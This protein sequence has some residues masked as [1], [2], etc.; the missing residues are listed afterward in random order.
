MCY[1]ANDCLILLQL[2]VDV[3]LDWT[4]D[5]VMNTFT[6]Q[7]GDTLVCGNNSPAAA[8]AADVAIKLP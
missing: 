5:I 7:K 3:D 4:T 1:S 6:L 8:A 2:G